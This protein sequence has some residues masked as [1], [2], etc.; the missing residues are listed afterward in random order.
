TRTSGAWGAPS[1]PRNGS[2]SRLSS[3]TC[4][5]SSSTRW[6]EAAISV[7]P[8]S[9]PWPTGGSTPAGGRRSWG[10]ATNWV[11]STMPF[12][13]PARWGGGISGKPRMLQARRSTRLADW[14]QWL[15]EGHLLPPLPGEGP[16]GGGLPIFGVAKLPLYLMD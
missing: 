5:T 3:T 13:W 16:G 2:S 9:W 4:T 14:L 11:A 10:W 7:A 1:P 12:A 15:L 6:R 8:P